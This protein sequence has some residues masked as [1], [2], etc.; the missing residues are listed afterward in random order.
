M[1]DKPVQTSTCKR[2]AQKLANWAPMTATFG[3]ES[4]EIGNV[5]ISVGGFCEDK[6][7]VRVSAGLAARA[8]TLPHSS[9]FAAETVLGAASMFAAALPKTFPGRH[10]GRH[11]SGH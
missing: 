4:V 10:W 6:S 11:G 7:R 3:W 9:S 2:R 5:P 8:A 1:L